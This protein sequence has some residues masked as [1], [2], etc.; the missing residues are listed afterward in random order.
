MNPPTPGSPE[1]RGR[2]MDAVQAL[3]GEH[4]TG[5]LLIAEYETPDGGTSTPM[6]WGGGFNR[7]LGLAVRASDRMRE[8]ARGADAPP[9]PEEGDEWK[10]AG[11]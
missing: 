5:F 11:H 9:D 7:A 3:L 10:R 2:I 6:T 4:C 8:K 1:H